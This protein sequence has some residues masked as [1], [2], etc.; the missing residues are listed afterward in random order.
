ME[1]YDLIIIGSGPAAYTASVYASRYKINHLII[2]AMPGGTASSAHRICNFPSYEEIPGLELMMKMR[3]QVASYGAEEI[4]DR[5]V[6][7]SKGDDGFEVETEGKLINT[8]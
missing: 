5:V 8:T 6:G 3:N 7:V 2:G 1:K 4:M